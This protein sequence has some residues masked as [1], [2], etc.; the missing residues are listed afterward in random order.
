MRANDSSIASRRSISCPPGLASPQTRTIR[1]HMFS[2]VSGDPPR[3]ALTRR[4]AWLCAR[5]NH[6]ATEPISAAP[7]VHLSCC[8]IPVWPSRVKRGQASSFSEKSAGWIPAAA[9]I[10]RVERPIQPG[11]TISDEQGNAG[12]VRVGC[13]SP[14]RT[15]SG[16]CPADLAAGLLK[17]DSRTEPG[18]RAPNEATAQGIAFLLRSPTQPPQLPECRRRESNPHPLAGTGF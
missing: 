4:L 17:C 13:E 2:R 14:P 8:I 6:R 12:L 3:T 1:V 18:T 15:L 5:Q 10:P 7:P 9:G 16:G 11:M